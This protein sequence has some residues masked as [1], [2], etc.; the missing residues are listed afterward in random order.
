MVHPC[1]MLNVRLMGQA[2]ERYGLAF[3][4]RPVYHITCANGLRNSCGSIPSMNQVSVGIG[5]PNG[6]IPLGFIEACMLLMRNHLSP[7]RPLVHNDETQLYGK[8][9]TRLAF[10]FQRSFFDIT[11]IIVV[12]QT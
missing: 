12:F 11:S 9:R 3:Y 8:M 10:L 5:F 7:W 1:F 2:G 6:S 4:Q